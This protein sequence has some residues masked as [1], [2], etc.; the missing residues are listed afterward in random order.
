MTCRSIFE[1][2]LPNGMVREQQGRHLNIY[3]CFPGR[4]LI[5]SEHAQDIH[6]KMD[7]LILAAADIDERA[8]YSTLVQE[9]EEKCWCW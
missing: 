7:Y 2:I 1:E 4:L 3:P 9:F 5:V 8:F 6:A